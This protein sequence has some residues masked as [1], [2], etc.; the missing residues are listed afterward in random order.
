MAASIPRPDTVCPLSQVRRETRDSSPIRIGY[1]RAYAR[2]GALAE[3][4]AQLS[5]H[6]C[7]TV[8]TDDV[9]GAA[10]IRPG[11][12]SAL[13]ALRT[14]DTLAVAA[15]DRLTWRV[16]ELLEIAAQVNA[17]G[18]SLW[19]AGSS[20]DTRSADGTATFRALA[21]FVAAV[22]TAREAEQGKSDPRQKVGA[23][24]VAKALARVRGSSV[25]MTQAARELG[26]SRA[27]LY[28]RASA[29]A[30]R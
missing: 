20:F 9:N 2:P 13:A 8:F 29:E 14:G 18:A 19:I 28:R 11:L 17:C 12:A 7:A 27:T 26:V 3:E 1:A 22:P 30:S 24:A 25:S 21:D 4:Q 5:A 6:G 10:V 23:P 16:D 15:L